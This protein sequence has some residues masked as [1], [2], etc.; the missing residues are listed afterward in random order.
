[1]GGVAVA[2]CL[3]PLGTR[4]P[5]CDH[6]PSDM[7]TQQYRFTCVPDHTLSSRIA[8][9]QDP[10]WLS[11][12]TRQEHAHRMRSRQHILLISVLS[13]R[14]E[15]ERVTMTDRSSTSRFLSS[16]SRTRSATCSSSRCTACLG[17]IRRTTRPTTL[18]EQDPTVPHAQAFTYS[19]KT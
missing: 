8:C 11:D 6:E 14:E 7:H 12:D 2:T 4:V 10:N 13:R 9:R 5:Q 18:L 19:Q 3:S 16:S 17:T 1:V 15:E